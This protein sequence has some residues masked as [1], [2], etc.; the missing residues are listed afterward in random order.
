[1]TAP[2]VAVLPLLLHH[3]YLVHGTDRSFLRLL[4]D[5]VFLDLVLLLSLAIHQVRIG[6]L[7]P[8][9]A[10]FHFRGILGGWDSRMSRNSRGLTMLT[11]W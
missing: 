8:G 9:Q 2:E 10:Y 11:P 7:G 6:Q 5:L 1:M 3:R 4:L